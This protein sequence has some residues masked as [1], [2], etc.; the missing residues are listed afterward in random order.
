MTQKLNKKQLLGYIRSG[1]EGMDYSYNKYYLTSGRPGSEDS[2]L[3]ACCAMGAAGIGVDRSMG[4]TAIFP[5]RMLGIVRG[6]VPEDIQ[7]M[8]HNINDRCWDE[9]YLGFVMKPLEEKK[10]IILNLLEFELPEWQS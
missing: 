1:W 10:E 8:I 6:M 9:N 3:V 4:V 5:G 2:K 7:R